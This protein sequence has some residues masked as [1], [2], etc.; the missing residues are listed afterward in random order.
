MSF[1]ATRTV[2][3]DGATYQIGRMKASDGSWVLMQ[4]LPSIAA[5]LALNDNGNA[6]TLPIDFIGRIIGQIGQ[7]DENTF[8]RIQAHALSVCRRME[9]GAPMPV[10]SHQGVFAIKE[11]EYDLVTV[12]TLTANA[13][14]FNLSPF[15][16]AGGLKQLFA[17]LLPDS[18]S[19]SPSV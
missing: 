19:P 17:S 7:T 16:N 10:V 13:L 12:M 15:F 9:H 1:E 5:G 11:L 3:I 14:V 8:R 6:K 4:L 2:E 18:T